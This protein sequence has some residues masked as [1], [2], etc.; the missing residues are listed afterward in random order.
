[1]I[2]TI[3]PARNVENRI[4]KTLKMLLKTKT[5][6]ILAVVNGCMDNTLQRILDIKSDRVDILNFNKPL[7]LDV[8]RAVGAY[9]AYK[10]GASTFVFVDGDMIGNIEKNINEIITDICEKGVD[11]AL[12]DCYPQKGKN[13]NMARILLAFRRQLNIELGIFDKIGYAIPSHGPHG[14]SKKIL[15][16]IGFR[17][18]AVP[19]VSLALALMFCGNIKV[20]TKISDEDLKSQVRDEFHAKQIANTIIGDCIEALSIFRGDRRK[21]GF[22]GEKFLGYH[23]NRRFDILDIVLDS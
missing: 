17:S 3:V 14:L 5:D 6:R 20:S 13:S 1:M 8:P 22:D 2:Y 19:P 4:D 23:K 16:K 18:L 10:E 11:M 21:R 12:T 15:E 7:G 9:T